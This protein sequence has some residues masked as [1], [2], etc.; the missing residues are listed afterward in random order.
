MMARLVLVMALLL[1]VGACGGD[2]DEAAD[3]VIPTSTTAAAVTTS[4]AATTLPAETT[5]TAASSTTV[6]DT[7]APPEETTTTA[8]ESELAG[9]LAVWSEDD[10]LAELGEGWSLI[11]VSTDETTCTYSAI[12]DTLVLSYR[13]GGQAEFD[14]AMAGA[15]LT[16][17]MMPV[18]AC[19]GAY[20][21]DVQ[22]AIF[23]VE[24]LDLAAGRI[25]N[26][27]LSGID[28]AIAIATGFVVSA[29]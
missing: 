6:V 5:T 15:G 27:T 19:D 7:T 20:S 12:P 14:A 18:T 21:V 26:V 11:Q 29:C 3:D 23:V 8:A 9:C 24:A 16:G 22:G 10:V 13:E 25:Y 17:A 1:V 2:D 4:E 28:D